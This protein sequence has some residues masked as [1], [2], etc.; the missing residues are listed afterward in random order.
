M[1][2]LIHGFDI[3]CNLSVFV[4]V[5][6]SGKSIDGVA[7]GVQALFELLLL[8]LH[9]LDEVLLLLLQDLCLLFDGLHDSLWSTKEPPLV[10]VLSTCELMVEL[11]ADVVGAHALVD[12]DLA[13]LDLDTNLLNIL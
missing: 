8:L 4:E 5:I 3:L 9:L 7:E 11:A 1:E 13:L 2:P 12:L 10:V 6:V